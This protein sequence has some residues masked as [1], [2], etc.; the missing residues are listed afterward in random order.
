MDFGQEEA[1]ARL[2]KA[3]PSERQVSP[4][5]RHCGQRKDAPT[6]QSKIGGKRQY[7][8]NGSFPFGK[9]TAQCLPIAGEQP[10]VDREKQNKQRVIPKRIGSTAQQI[11][12]AEKAK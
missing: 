8:Q 2:K 6:Q 5:Y 11:A 7:K 1:A 12:D 3:A 10:A 9:V 4:C